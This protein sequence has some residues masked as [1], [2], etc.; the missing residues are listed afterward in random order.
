M[1]SSRRLV[2]QSN[3]EHSR[4]HEVQ[5]RNCAQIAGSALPQ[6]LFSE[7]VKQVE[8]LNPRWLQHCHYSRSSG[9][10]FNL[11]PKPVCCAKLLL[12]VSLW[13]ALNVPQAPRQ[14]HTAQHER[15]VLPQVDSLEARHHRPMIEPGRLQRILPHSSAPQQSSGDA[16]KHTNE[17]SLLA[18]LHTPSLTFFAPRAAGSPCSKCSARFQPGFCPIVTVIPIVVPAASQASKRPEQLTQLHCKPFCSISPKSPNT[19]PRWRPLVQELSAA[20]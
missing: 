17:A 13:Q 3:H 15:S 1:R 19:R 6:Q 18:L 2:A 14:Q 4:G 5:A 9:Q 8:A 11:W 16:K 20:L 10:H 12:R 7:C